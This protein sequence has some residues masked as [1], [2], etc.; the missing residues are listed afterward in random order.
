MQEIESRHGQSESQLNF[1]Q[2]SLHSLAIPKSGRILHLKL[3]LEPVRGN[4]NETSRSQTTSIVAK[5]LSLDNNPTWLR[6]SIKKQTLNANNVI[7][8]KKIV[9]NNIILI[10]YT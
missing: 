1:L 5:R 10:F 2:S 8:K 9:L 4:L 7:I 3:P 6:D